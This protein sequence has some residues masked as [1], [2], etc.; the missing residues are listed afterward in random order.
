MGSATD[1]SS[2]RVDFDLKTQDGVL[3]ALYA[4]RTS[5]LAMDERNE[6]RDQLFTLSRS[7]DSHLEE[8][9]VERLKSLPLTEAYV[10][11]MKA[12]QKS[13]DQDSQNGLARSRKT[14]KFSVRASISVPETRNESVV[15]KVTKEQAV[16]SKSPEAA[17][18]TDTTPA[19][20]NVTEAPTPIPGQAA[21][22]KTETA[23][24]EASHTGA[25]QQVTDHEVLPKEVETESR[26]PAKSKE[27]PQTL[28]RIREIKRFV[29]ERIGNPVNL[30]D[31]DND[32]GRAYMTALLAAMQSVNNE[33]GTAGS[34]Q[35]QELERVF[36][37]VQSLLE[38]Q[39][40]SPQS[41]PV[42]SQQ[43]TT[44]ST[45]P[46]TPARPVSAPRES[47]RLD[48]P[49][50]KDT[51]PASWVDEAT[52]KAV[53]QGVT[54]SQPQT[55]QSPQTVERVE[56]AA[57]SVLDTVTDQVSQPKPEPSAHVATNHDQITPQSVNFDQKS[58]QTA[59]V[60]A[61][62]PS[63]DGDSGD[64]QRTTSSLPD[65]D[66]P[67]AVSSPTPTQTNPAAA[68]TTENTTPSE[69]SAGLATAAQ[70]NTSQ[71]MSGN[72]VPVRTADAGPEPVSSSV[73]TS[74]PPAQIDTQPTTQPSVAPSA[75]AVSKDIPDSI[76][77]K[78]AHLDA[79]AAE[80]NKYD[81]DPLY[82]PEVD[83]GLE[84]L[85][86]EWSLFKASGL[87]GTG[88]NGREHP[89]FKKLAPQ[90]V[91]DI[92]LGKFDGSRPEIIQSITDYMN[93]WRYEQGIVY[94]PGE[95]FETYLRRVIRFI[96][97]N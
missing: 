88:P 94:Q 46:P 93:G 84:Q 17:P 80:K 8:Q 67:Q 73:T 3:Q 72:P 12:H 77:N 32:T 75:P 48:T 49:E 24:A 52:A 76:D 1:R 74:V 70:T 41:A 95:T 7:H 20:K 43:T 79:V 47:D 61:P 44:D 39:P 50:S 81:G 82:A 5:D 4:V 58:E 38:K 6:L 37:Q 30:V 28:D 11:V 92:L 68:Q 21:E 14:P 60:Q 62:V 19:P 96:I 26:P 69:A 22:P 15:E 31:L 71:G 45:N 36:V 2:Q 23:P 29:N 55:Q 66:I 25:S 90:M 53:D 42:T 34:A 27:F 85:L 16:A 97:D 10:S 9:L 51:P 35:M 13:A 83:A 40:S 86:M 91:N 89:L 64:G 56:S 63:S 57:R 18:D 33:T 65:N 78:I 59:A 54:P 87:F